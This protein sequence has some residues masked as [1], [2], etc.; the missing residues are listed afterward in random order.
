MQRVPYKALKQRISVVHFT[1][2]EVTEQTTSTNLAFGKHSL[3]KFFSSFEGKKN[4]KKMKF[5]FHLSYSTLI[6]GR[7]LN[8]LT[9]SSVRTKYMADPSFFACGR[10]D[11]LQADSFSQVGGATMHPQLQ[12]TTKLAGQR[13]AAGCW[14]HFFP[15]KKKPLIDL[16]R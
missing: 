6:P 10:A 2:F 3:W 11:R 13:T 16:Q 14:L 7:P 1:N 8:P 12:A 9:Y 5:F 15:S 4:C